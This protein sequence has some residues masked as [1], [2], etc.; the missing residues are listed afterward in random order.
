MEAV[1]QGTCVVG[2]KNSHCVVLAAL[3]KRH[4][5][6][7]AFQHKIFSIDDHMAI[8]IAG[9]TA[10]ARAIAQKLRRHCAEHRAEF[11]SLPPVVRAASL[12]ADKA[13][14]FTQ[15]S[16]KRPYGVGVLVAGVDALGPHLYEI[17]PAGTLSEY[18]AHAIGARNQGART[19][20]ENAAV[21]NGERGSAVGSEGGEG[22]TDG[23]LGAMGREAMLRL[24]LRALRGAAGEEGLSEESVGIAVV[25]NGG[26]VEVLEG[27][28]VREFMPAE[29][30]EGDLSGE[31]DEAV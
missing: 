23:G 14:A 5:K 28:T 2:I 17:S 16:E 3:R 21:G 7:A 8:G 22:G 25:L 15:R 31:E 9:L 13:Q 29:V 27:A 18:R 12:V 6:L 20:L 1:N 26:K 11:G 4:S 24:A 10:D 30:E 19:V